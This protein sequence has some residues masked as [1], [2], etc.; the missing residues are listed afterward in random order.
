MYIHYHGKRTLMYH[1]VKNRLQNSVDVTTELY[2]CVWCVFWEQ[3]RKK[4]DV[5]KDVKNISKGTWVIIF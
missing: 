3:V 1:Y 4:T 2:V 5:Q